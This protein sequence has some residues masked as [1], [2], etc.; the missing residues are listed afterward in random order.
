MQVS[1]VSCL[2]THT[3]QVENLLPSCFVTHAVA[4]AAEKTVQEKS[5]QDEFLNILVKNGTVD[6]NSV[7]SSDSQEMN[8]EPSQLTNQ[9]RKCSS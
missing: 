4:K 9:Y 6:G 3:E 2:V 7:I 5:R 8:R 1:D